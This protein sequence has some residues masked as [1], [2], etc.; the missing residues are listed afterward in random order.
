MVLSATIYVNV[1]GVW[2]PLC[3]R[4]KGG[5]GEAFSEKKAVQS[6]GSQRIGG[7]LFQKR[8]FGMGLCADF[9]LGNKQEQKDQS[10]G[11]EEEEFFNHCKE[12][13]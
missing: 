10:W 3:L 12:R 2:G 4:K 7:N 11:G 1:V 9:F 8:T 5:G 13:P 6:A